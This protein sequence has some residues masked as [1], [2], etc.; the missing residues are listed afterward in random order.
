M[1]PPKLKKCPSTSDAFQSLPYTPASI[2]S[3]SQ[4]D[5]SQDK[6]DTVKDTRPEHERKYDTVRLG[7]WNADREAL[8]W[9]RPNFGVPRDLF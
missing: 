8:S 6:R 1:S 5:A 3:I 2:M 4:S 9:L 7:D